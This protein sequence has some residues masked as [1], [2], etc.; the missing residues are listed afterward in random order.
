MLG[1]S[2]MGNNIWHHVTWWFFLGWTLL[3]CLLEIQLGHDTALIVS[4]MY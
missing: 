2:L 1:G 3:A 4:I